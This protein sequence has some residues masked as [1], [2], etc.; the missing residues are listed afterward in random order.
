MRKTH[1]VLLT[2]VCITIALV[3]QEKIIYL[4]NG[5]VLKGQV[6]ETDTAIRI[7]SDRYGVVEIQKK[8]VKKILDVDANAL[9]ASERDLTAT[10]MAAGSSRENK[11]SVNDFNV[12]SS[13]PDLKPL[14]KGFSELISYEVKKSPKVRLVEREKRNELFKEMEVSMTGA[15]DEKDQVKAGKILACDYIVFGEIVDMAGSLMLSLRMTKVESGEVVWRKQLTE[16]GKNY[17]YISAFFAKDILS[18]LNLGVDKSIDETLAAKKG[19]DQ[20]AVV[21][22]S[23]G[24]DAYDNKDMAKARTELAEAKKID[25]ENQVVKAFIN[26]LS[27]NMSKFKT[28]PERYGIYANPAYLGVARTDRLYASAA[29]FNPQNFDTSKGS[30]SASFNWVNSAQGI[31]EAGIVGII[32]YFLPVVKGFGI[33]AEYMAGDQNN[34]IVSNNLSSFG[35]TGEPFQG[36]SLRLGIA[37]N[38]NIGIGI[39]GGIANTRFAMAGD[40]AAVSN[41]VRDNTGVFFENHA[42]R[43]YA[44]SW[45]IGIG[46]LIKNSDET[47]VFDTVINYDS[48]PS[49]YYSQ[50]ATNYFKNQ[51]PIF[52]ENTLTLAFNGRWTSLVFKEINEIYYSQ[53]GF[54]LKFIP[55][56]EQ[57]LFDTGFFALSLRAGCE[58]V[59][60][61]MGA[62]PQFGIGAIAGITPRFKFFDRTTLDLD[63][64][65]TY[66][67]RPSRI[68]PQNLLPEHVVYLM[69]SLSGLFVDR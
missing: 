8:Y 46:F 68:M 35:R 12:T 40:D 20:K 56:A 37:V 69:L 10:G 53:G 23:K 22:L 28:I 50:E 11:I 16:P 44:L 25:P 39:S 30:T 63:V 64:N 55:A 26:K 24:I 5:E 6:K 54:V 60:A 67:W 31:R 57:W 29:S 17:P 21:M 7:K 41:F 61:K 65:Y 1:I 59:F 38:E 19:M 18:V 33:A 42:W 62:N 45:N 47:V 13:N 27:G 14:G 66:R 2:L 34:D 4:D 51:V 15:V 58:A 36:G 3:P 48:T 49:I 9:L 52:N 32:G 43:L